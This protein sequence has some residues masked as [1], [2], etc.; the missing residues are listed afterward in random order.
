MQQFK[1]QKGRPR[2]DLPA[3]IHELGLEPGVLNQQ[4]S[5]LSVSLSLTTHRPF[6]LQ[7]MCPVVHT[8]SSSKVEALH[9]HIKTVGLADHDEFYEKRANLFNRSL[10]DAPAGLTRCTL[11]PLHRI[12]RLQHGRYRF[13]AATGLTLQDLSC[14]RA[15]SRVSLHN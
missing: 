14:I 9:C 2:S 15:A 12:K 11:L 10:P 3:I 6:Y 8:A 7:S 5:E 1:A 4:W 13:G